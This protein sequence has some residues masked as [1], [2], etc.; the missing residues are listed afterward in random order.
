MQVLYYL[1]IFL[2]NKLIRTLSYFFINQMVVK[3][4]EEKK[5]KVV[6]IF[7][8]DLDD[9]KEILKRKELWISK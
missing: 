9:L 3:C 4:Y 1:L 6:C 5:T 7:E 8:R 2:F